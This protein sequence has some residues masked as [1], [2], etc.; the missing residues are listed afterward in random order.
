MNLYGGMQFNHIVQGTARD[1]MVEG[2]F[3]A[4]KAGYRVVL[5]VHDE[6]LTEA[7][8]GFG[9]AKELEDIMSA[10]PAWVVGD[11]PLAAKAWE[12][13]RYDK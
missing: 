7:P 6:L 5:T 11:L 8:H 2:M 4:E 10:V 1:I 3:G 9:S 12:G 13:M